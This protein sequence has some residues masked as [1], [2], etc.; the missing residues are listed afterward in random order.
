MQQC[1]DNEGFSTPTGTSLVRLTRSPSAYFG[2]RE[3][4]RSAKAMETMPPERLEA[5]RKE[6]EQLDANGSGRIDFEEMA[7][8]MRELGF[9]DDE[10]RVRLK[11]GDL[12]GDFP[13]G[14]AVEGPIIVGDDSLDH[15]ERVQIDFPSGPLVSR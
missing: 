11:K 12:D 8:K 6:F 5:L 1:V 15:L 2:S 9:E 10:I 3:R 7:D 13:V 4:P 14:G